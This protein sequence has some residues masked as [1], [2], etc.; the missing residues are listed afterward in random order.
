MMEKNGKDPSKLDDLELGMAN[1]PLMVDITNELFDSLSSMTDFKVVQSPFFNLLEGTQAVEVSNPKLDTGLIELSLEDLQFDT[2]KPQSIDA[3]IGIQ[4]KLLVLL[5]SWL[6]NSNLPVTILSCRYVQTL[7]VNYTRSALNPDMSLVEKCSLTDCRLPN[8]HSS[9]DTFES[10]MVHTVLK[11]FIMGLCKFIGFSLN[12]AMNI[13][14]EEEDLTT[15]NMN[16]DFLLA[17]PTE[18]VLEELEK[19]ISWLK[20]NQDTNNTKEVNNAIDQLSIVLQLNKIQSIFQTSLSVLDGYKPNNLNLDYLSNGIAALNDLGSLNYNSIPSGTFSKFIQ[21]DLDNKNIPIDLYE[22]DSATAY[23]NL[24]GIFSSILEFMRNSQQIQNY[25][26]LLNYLHFDI[27]RNIKSFNVLSRGIFQLHL[28]RDDK[29]IF[30]SKDVNLRTCVTGFIVN[31]VGENTSILQLNQIQNWGI[32]QE[33]V[34]EVISSIDQL[35][36]ELESATYHTLSLYGNNPCRQQ[37]LISKGLLLWDTLQVTWESFESE[38]YAQFKVG[39]E[40]VDGGL[41]LTVSSYIFFVKMTLMNELLL[42]GIDLEL[43]KPYEM[44]LVYWFSAYLIRTIVELLQGRIQAILLSKI[45]F[46]EKTL[47]KRLKKLK[48]GSKKQQLKEQI[49]YNQNEVLPR[50]KGILLYQADF[51]IPSFHGMAELIEAVKTFLIIA[52]SFKLIDFLESTPNSLTTFETLFNL[53]MKPWSSI[54]SP[55]LPTFNQYKLSLN[56]KYLQTPSMDERSSKIKTLLSII[57][58]KLTSSTEIHQSLLKSLHENS[59]INTQLLLSTSNHLE[60]WINGLIK[61]SMHYSD[62]V[63]KLLDLVNQNKLEQITPQ[64]Y[65]LTFNRGHHDYF[66]IVSVEKK[67][68]A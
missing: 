63:N 4:S 57:Q 18:V 12:V 67:E 55:R 59:L 58:K 20:S 60:T 19:S 29:S 68:L 46:I 39:D 41:A 61:T 31:L 43:Y 40:L 27:S 47:P 51:M 62:E 3:V 6:N 8:P 56:M 1:S 17:V 26:Q 5:I 33:M 50:L 13:L 21:L 14:Y 9:Q 30:G 54:G 42:R 28:I 66:P 24:L 11:S 48:A 44:Y 25:N 22:I 52:S 49:T 45:N 36:L 23:D 7:L 53:R 37:Q 64:N 34:Q 38:M 35:T 32:K 65:Q 15:R 10:K 2:S 16:L